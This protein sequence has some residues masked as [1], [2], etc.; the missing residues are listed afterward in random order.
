MNLPEIVKTLQIDDNNNNQK[1]Y[2]HLK[3]FQLQIF[4]YSFKLKIGM[5]SGFGKC[6]HRDPH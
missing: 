1:N 6:L 5:E 2:G 4:L 3:D